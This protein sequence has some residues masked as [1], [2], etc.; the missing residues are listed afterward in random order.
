MKK[1]SLRSR[2]LHKVPKPSSAFPFFAPK[3]SI[4]KEKAQ[5]GAGTLAE[6]GKEETENHYSRTCW[7]ASGGSSVEWL[8]YLERVNVGLEF[9]RHLLQVRHSEMLT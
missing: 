4:V 6:T 7:K 5:T 2:F 1:R 8:S 3:C 9:H